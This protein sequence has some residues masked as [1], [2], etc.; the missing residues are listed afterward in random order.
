MSTGLLPKKH[1]ICSEREREK[2][3]QWLKL[4]GEE[5]WGRGGQ[6]QETWLPVI[7]ILLCRN[8]TACLW[9]ECWV[10]QKHAFVKNQKK[11][12]RENCAKWQ[13][14]DLVQQWGPMTNQTVKHIV[15]FWFCLSASRLQPFV[16]LCLPPQFSTVCCFH[17]GCSFSLLHFPSLGVRWIS[18]WC[19][20]C[21]EACSRISLASM[22]PCKKQQQQPPLEQLLPLPHN[23]S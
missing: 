9:T 5:V 17:V 1:S 20:G 14:W 4:K 11:E 18:K 10:K 6:E 12:G 19:W 22:V 2:I 16:S 15:C 21:L 23:L 7:R 8:P 13:K 3:Y